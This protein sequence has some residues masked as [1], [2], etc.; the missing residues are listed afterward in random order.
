VKLY[1]N[2]AGTNFIERHVAAGL[3]SSAALYWAAW[4]DY[5]A[6]GW[7]DLAAATGGHYAEVR[8]NRGTAGIGTFDG[9][10]YS[11]EAPEGCRPGIV[12]PVAWI[13]VDGDGDQDLL[14]SQ[15][16]ADLGIG[17]CSLGLVLLN[18]GESPPGFTAVSGNPWT[19]FT[20][21]IQV[22]SLAYGRL[23]PEASAYPDLVMGG[24]YERILKGL[25]A[26]GYQTTYANTAELADPAGEAQL[27][28]YDT[29]GRMEAIFYS[30]YAGLNA[31]LL[32][33]ESNGNWTDVTGPA[34]V[35]AQGVRSAIAA[36]FDYD[37]DTDLLQGDTIS[38]GVPGTIFLENFYSDA[39]ICPPPWGPSGPCP[40]GGDNP[41]NGWLKVQ[42]VGT[43][44]GQYLTDKV[45]NS[46][47]IGT[48][49]TVNQTGVAQWVQGSSG[50]STGAS[51]PLLFGL[52]SS[53]LGTVVVRWP[54]GIETTE[55]TYLP[56]QTVTI[57]DQSIPYVKDATVTCAKY[58]GPGIVTFIW[59]WMDGGPATTV[60]LDLTY[61][62]GGSECH[63]YETTL[64]PQSLGC[65]FAQTKTTGG[66]ACTFSWSTQP[67]HPN[68]WFEYKITA[69][70]GVAT[71]WSQKHTVKITSCIGG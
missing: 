24:R 38:G 59:S 66:Y 29:D 10:W 39:T 3:E 47:L 12:G 52:G 11:G 6:D 41:Y 44:Y 65:A 31:T 16:D 20:S 63:D 13:D 4:G 25:G 48:R 57:A 22:G 17:V 15:R 37:G 43:P 54:N 18:D 50:N 9:P 34:L 61:K 51:V 56:N 30:A 71:S 8:H 58:F 60:K 19:A 1:E 46:D 7:V 69:D 35:E 55:G 27:L 14:V 62:S 68:C 70:N 64:T 23:V 5:D 49:V 42:L 67:C 21:P 32:R 36:D 28:D 40:S 33:Q 26:A 53:T 45:A 2:Q